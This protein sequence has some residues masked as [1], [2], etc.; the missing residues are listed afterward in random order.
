MN[1]SVQR[2]LQVYTNGTDTVVAYD[3][4]DAKAVFAEYLGCTVEDGDVTDTDPFEPVPHNKPIT[5]NFTDADPGEP[6]KQ[7]RTAAGWAEHEGRGFLCS[8]EY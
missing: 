6:T 7:E 4:D 1:D 5:I 8:T 2:T 3:V